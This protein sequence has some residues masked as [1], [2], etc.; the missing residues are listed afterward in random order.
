MSTQANKTMVSMSA[1]FNWKSSCI[2]I[3][4]RCVLCYLIIFVRRQILSMQSSWAF[5][6]YILNSAAAVATVCGIIVVEFNRHKT[7]S[8]V[9]EIESITSRWIYLVC[10][11]KLLSLNFECVT[12]LF[13]FE[14]PV[15]FYCY[16]PFR[17]KCNGFQSN[18]QT[19]TFI[20]LHKY[21]HVY[22]VYGRFYSTD[23]NA[24]SK[25][26]R[27]N[28]NYDNSATAAS[29]QQQLTSNRTMKFCIWFMNSEH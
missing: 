4:T 12:A 8:H 7:D 6:F 13:R 22:R 17:N 21:S 24:E 5:Q 2:L 29:S 16:S 3:L 27:G 20:W 25:N 23:W 14:A 28:N 19:H 15:L 11:W 1:V 10:C 18:R 26:E 9:F